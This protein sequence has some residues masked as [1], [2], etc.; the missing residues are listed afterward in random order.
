MPLRLAHR[1]KIL[2]LWLLS[3]CTMPCI[4]ERGFVLVQV[5]DAQGR[6]VRGIEIKIE[7]M[8]G[9][10][11]TGDDGEA[12]L[13]VGAATKEGDA[14]SL[15]ILH[16]PPGKDYVM[17]SPWDSRTAV[18]SFENKA[19]NFIKVVVVQRGD[20]ATLENG[21]VLASL[22][23]KINKA[24]APKTADKQA[25]PLD[26]RK[27]LEAVA[28]Q[29]GLSADEVD[30]AIRKWGDNTTDPYEA[31]MAAL[32]ERNY[33]KASIE[34]ETSLKMRETQLKA[35]QVTVDRDQK[36]VA[37]AAAFLGVSLYQEGRYRESVD[38]YEK[39]LRIH[40]DDPAVLNNTALSLE[41]AGDYARAEPL[42]RQALVIDEKALGMDSPEVATNLNNLAELLEG[43][44][45]Y[46][47]AEP[48]FRRALAIN[49]K[50]L[51]SNHPDV[52]TTLSGLAQL[53]RAKNDYGEAE[54]LL[55]QALA[56]DEKVFGPDHPS[57]AMIQ[58][59]L[60]E[61]LEDEAD[62]PGAELLLRKALAIDEKALR[63]DHPGLARDLGNL[64]EL[65]KDEHNYAEAEPLVRRALEIGEKALGPDHPD[66]AIGLNNLAQ[67]LVYKGDYDEAEP[68][69]RQALA[70]DEKA[71]GPDHPLVATNL[72]N[73]ARLLKAKGDYI[74][75]EPLMRRALAIDEKALGPENPDVAM[76]LDNIAHLLEAKGDCAGAE[77]LYR[78]ALAI[79]KKA[80]GTDH[81][82]T[83]TIQ[84]D[85]DQML[86]K[87]LQ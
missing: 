78:Q 74:E 76:I 70:I 33:P 56:I 51:G 77:P 23:E 34:L 42:F 50:A 69:L 75:A 19:D 1:K 80:L 68:L 28:Q 12:K 87:P 14:I 38:A 44:G 6:A 45:E 67:L 59:S 21:A 27:N 53:F 32:Y 8:G 18:P 36:Q 85:L 26:P 13:S 61:M 39:C 35:D 46:A 52:A 54:R 58:S 17:N 66:V 3:L 49:E 60:G 55:R 5:Q 41:Y 2:P 4:A 83:K 64:E 24:N 20:R 81:P 72:N 40:T 31:G 10:S 84:S 25:E 79:A 71:L 65:Y 37:D 16:S 82:V 30:S 7:G 47:E 43:K 63:P 48:L 15:A 57:V 29:Y 86:R 62:Y 73:L 11:V 9:S 22:M